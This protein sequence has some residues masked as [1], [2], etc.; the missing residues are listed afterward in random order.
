MLPRMPGGVTPG[1]PVALSATADD[2]RYNNTNGTEPTQ[3]IAAAEY[4]ID[5]PP[6]ITDPAPVA[7]PMTAADGSF[8]RED[9]GCYRHDR[10]HRAERWAGI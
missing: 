5:T 3:N 10:Y 8:R 2:T 9:R 1:E 6:W 7:H 4:Y